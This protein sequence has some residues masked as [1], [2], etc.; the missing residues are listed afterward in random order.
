MNDVVSYRDHVV[1]IFQGDEDLSYLHEL[2][3][4]FQVT[5]CISKVIYVCLEGTDDTELDPSRF[6]TENYQHSLN[7]HLLWSGCLTPDEQEKKIWQIVDEFI[8]NGK[9]ILVEEYEFVEDEPFYDYSGGR[10]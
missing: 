3:L 10:E 7:N 4:N 5:D 2:Q 8:D 6:V 1:A 9:R